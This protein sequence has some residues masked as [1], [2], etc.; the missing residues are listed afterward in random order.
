[1]IKNEQRICIK[2][3]KEYI[4]MVN[5]HTKMLKI[6]HNYEDRNQIQDVLLG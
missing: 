4:K 5:E 2:F 1:M 3:W 6:V